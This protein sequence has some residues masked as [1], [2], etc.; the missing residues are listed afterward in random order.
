MARV[1]I[2]MDPHKRSATIEIINSREKVLA[3]RRF[4]TDRDGYAAMLKLGRQS[5]SVARGSRHVRAGVHAVRMLVFSTADRL[6]VNERRSPNPPGESGMLPGQAG[7]EH[8]V[9]YRRGGV[10]RAG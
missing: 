2:G 9:R 7:A 1:I 5:R 8:T 6:K 10:S 4:G 3:Q